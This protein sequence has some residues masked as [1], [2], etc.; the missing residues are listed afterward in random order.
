MRGI[1]EMVVRNYF[2]VLSREVSTSPT[3]WVRSLVEEGLST[4]IQS[5]LER[6]GII[7]TRDDAK[8]D[9]NETDSRHYLPRQTK[10]FASCLLRSLLERRYDVLM[11]VRRAM[12][13]Y[14]MMFGG[15]LIHKY[16]NCNEEHPI[17][18]TY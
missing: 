10:C 7:M 2:R 13:H 8:Q 3:I 9:R 16:C 1:N 14:G 11:V 18:E 17:I 15:Q 12:E 6:R 5:L 4:I